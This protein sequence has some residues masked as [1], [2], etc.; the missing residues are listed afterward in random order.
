MIGVITVHPLTFVALVASAADYDNETVEESARWVVTCNNVL[1]I[2]WYYN[3]VCLDH[4][5]YA[6]TVCSFTRPG[7]NAMKM[8]F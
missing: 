1:M 4:V 5:E 2:G 7:P 3:A 8:P 6:Q